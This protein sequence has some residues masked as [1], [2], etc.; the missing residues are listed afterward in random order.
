MPA[1]FFSVDLPPDLVQAAPTE[2]KEKVEAS[3]RSLADDSV[4]RQ[5]ELRRAASCSLQH[6]RESWAYLSWFEIYAGNQ[7]IDNDSNGVIYCAHKT[8]RRP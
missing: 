6:T 3:D 8:E 1:W 5:D 4:F 7:S 2:I